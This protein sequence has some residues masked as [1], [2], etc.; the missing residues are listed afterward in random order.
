MELNVTVNLDKGN[1]KFYIDGSTIS[2]SK[3]GFSASPLKF[4]Y[5]NIFELDGNK[6]VFELPLDTAIG[7]ANQILIL[8][9]N[10]V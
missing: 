8:A 2:D 9:R 3:F 6:P 5:R 10:R 1:C 7:L 4:D